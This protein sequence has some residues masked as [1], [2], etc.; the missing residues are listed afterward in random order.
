MGGY[1]H[2]VEPGTG[3]EAHEVSFLL[4]RLHLI[5]EITSGLGTSW[6]PD[7]MRLLSMEVMSFTK[8]KSAC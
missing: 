7:L 5:L 3:I 2:N 8:V 1:Y 4:V 6:T